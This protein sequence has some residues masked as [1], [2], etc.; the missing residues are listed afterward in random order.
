MG[1]AA[2]LM[3]PKAAAKESDVAEDIEVWEGKVNRL[4]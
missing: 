3:D 1:Q 4:A 2:K